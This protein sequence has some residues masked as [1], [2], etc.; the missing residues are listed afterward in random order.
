[1][2]ARERSL[3]LEIQKSQ[4][5]ISKAAYSILKAAELTIS[6]T[7]SKKDRKTAL[8]TILTNT[9]DALG[10]ITTANVNTNK[11]RRDLILKKLAP[12]QRI[13]G[14]NI[15]TDDNLLFGENMPKRLTEA[16][17]ASKL[18]MKP[19]ESNFKPFSKNDYRPRK[20]SPG[21]N[22][23]KGLHKRHSDTR[24]KTKTNSTRTEGKYS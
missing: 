17:S 5:L 8:K 18:K 13:I 14:K 10:L 11:M 9:T 24:R 3:D 21:A 19:Y 7:K 22:T 20:P 12:E 16:A 15:P 23:R 2:S 4:N 6:A 1:M